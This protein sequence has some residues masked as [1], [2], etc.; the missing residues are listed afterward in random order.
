MLNVFKKLTI[1]R[2]FNSAFENSVNSA[3]SKSIFSSITISSFE[4]FECLENFADA[5][6]ATLWLS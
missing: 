3:L 4:N 2:N 6:K 1:N 5:C